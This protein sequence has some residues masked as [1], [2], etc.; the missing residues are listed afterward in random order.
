[1]RWQE[2]GVGKVAYSNADVTMQWTEITAGIVLKKHTDAITKGE[3][4]DSCMSATDALSRILM[5]DDKTDEFVIPTVI[6]GRRSTCRNCKR[7]RLC[8][9]LQLPT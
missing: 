6:N 4:R 9:L 5:T 3:G 1:M 7:Q 8:D 2:I